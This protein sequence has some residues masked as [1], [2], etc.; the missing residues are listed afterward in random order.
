MLLK[1]IYNISLGAKIIVE[2]NIP[3]AGGLGGGTSNAAF[4]IKHLTI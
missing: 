4:L 1:E 3:I 2:K